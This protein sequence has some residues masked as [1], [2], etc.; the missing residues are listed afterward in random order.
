MATEV[1][2]SVVI[3]N[4]NYGRFLKDCIDS[5]LSQTYRNVEVVVVDDGST[6]DSREIIASYASKGLVRPVLKENGGQASAFNEGF[7]ASRGDV[8]IFLDADDV[9]L[10][11]AVETAISVWEPSLTKVQWRLQLVDEGLRPV[12]ETAPARWQPMLSGDVRHLELRWGYHPSPP[13]SGNAFSRWLLE[14][15]LPIPERDWVIAADSYVLTLAGLLGPIRSID[16]VLGYYRIHG[17]NQW[18][19][20]DLDVMKLL[21]EVKVHWAKERLLIS[22][23]AGSEAKSRF[24]GFPTLWKLRL[25]LAVLAPEKLSALGLPGGRLRLAICGLRASAGFPFFDSA[26]ARLRLA[27]WFLLVGVLPSSVARSLAL[28][29]VTPSQRPR[30]LRWVSPKLAR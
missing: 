11:E 21:R 7:R 24:I 22:M 4:Y 18:Y 1:L 26:L 25:A 12:D 13:T 30:W 6:D 3:N 23:I 28:L 20:V 9:L 8:I 19:S 15:I 10:P 5:A 16:R 27:L 2:V 29:G 14:R 17:R